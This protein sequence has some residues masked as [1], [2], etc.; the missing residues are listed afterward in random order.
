MSA[1][2]HL[3]PAAAAELD[4]AAEWYENQQAGLGRDLVV[5]VGAAIRALASSPGAGSPIDGIRPG[6][7]VR[8]VRVARFPYQVVYVTI[9]EDVYVIAVAHERRQPGYWSDRTGLP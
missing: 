8:R 4:E 3:D 1:R 7:D 9:D 6:L 2:G 5:E